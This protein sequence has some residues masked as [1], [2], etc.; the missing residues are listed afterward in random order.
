MENCEL[1]GTDNVQGQISVHI[2]EAKWRL[3]F[4]KERL[5]TYC[6]VYT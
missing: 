3:L 4:Y 2:F 5:H 1:Q 6:F